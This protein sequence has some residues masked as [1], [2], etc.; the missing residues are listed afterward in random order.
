[1]E[2]AAGVARGTRGGGDRIGSTME[3]ATVVACGRGEGQ[4]CARR[5]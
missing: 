2:A 3:A 5:W 1:V 4:W